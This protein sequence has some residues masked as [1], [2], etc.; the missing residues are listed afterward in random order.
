ML[1][2][3]MTEKK[4]VAQVLS[5]YLPCRIRLRLPAAPTANW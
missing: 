1:N 5:F 3:E 2:N 4:F